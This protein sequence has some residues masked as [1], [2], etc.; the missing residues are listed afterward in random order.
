MV[1]PGISCRPLILNPAADE[2]AK[3]LAELQ[4]RPEVRIC[5]ELDTQLE[6]LAI[7][8]S[9]KARLDR[10]PQ[11]LADEVLALTA[12]PAYQGRRWV[13]YPWCNR[14]VHLL[15]P[16][17]FAE[18][19]SNR[20]LF[21]LDPQQQRDLR[22]KTV[23][24][25]GLSVGRAS[26]AT[27]ALEGLAGCYRLADFDILELSNLN[28]LRCSVADLG[29]NKAVLAAQELYE[30]DP[31][32]DIEVYTDGITEDNIEDFLGGRGGLDLLVE[33]C[34]ELSMKVLLRERCRELR[35][36][37]IMETSDRGM[38]DVERF[39]L[40][41]TRPLLHGL[42]DDVAAASLKGLSDK[43]KVPF[44]LRVLGAT[45]MSVDLAASL[46]EVGE[47]IT[48]WPQLASAVAVGGGIVG[49]FSRRILL[50]QHRESGRF[51]VDL[52]AL[53]HPDRAVAIRV[54]EPSPSEPALNEPL[55]SLRG[56]VASTEPVTESDVRRLV[57]YGIRAP[58]GGNNQG[59]TF[60]FDG[61]A[62]EC[63]IDPTRVQSFLEFNRTGSTLSLGAAVENIVLA[64]GMMSVETDIDF[65]PNGPDSDVLCR[66]RLRNAADVETDPLSQWIDERRTSRAR[67]SGRR[68]ESD[69]ATA[70]EA[71]VPGHQVR[72]QL[73]STD[74]ELQAVA[75]I[76]GTNDRV[77][78]Q[79]EAVHR[80]LMGDVR[81][82]QRELDTRKDGLD[83]T[84]FD[85]RPFEMAAMRVLTRWPVMEKLRAGNR[86][87]TL[88]TATRRSVEAS[89][90][91]GLLSVPGS[92]AKAYF[93]GG[94]AAQ[95]MWLEV[96]RL[97][98]AMQP[99]TVLPA[100]LARLRRGGGEGLGEWHRA[101]LTDLGD[102]FDRLY[103][104]PSDSA[105]IMLFR[106][107][108]APIEPS[109]SV[110]R[111]I[112]DVFSYDPQ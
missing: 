65:Q 93:E 9:P 55:P 22:T 90:A 23:G 7:C 20:N 31:Y 10:D 42:M 4:A 83:L 69:H 102:R 40:E 51:Y 56:G 77:A 61:S 53:L 25:V 41:P 108:Y 106:L 11:R 60:R 16:D 30:I 71:S 6:G 79:H 3:R 76:M 70:I 78:M 62:L 37:V 45:D 49:D 43:E 112:D 17:E 66:I 33:E 12:A 98:V 92:D 46:V 82:T 59:W 32:L 72:L 103:P 68:L 38:V 99:M 19:R 28:R 87:M 5:D 95:R 64:A 91:I 81:W 110:R 89:A 101:L 34:D 100:L 85:M 58:S 2:D 84:T 97:G 21:K 94:R 86:G 67:G 24:V 48:G 57:Q 1:I 15:G 14:L 96:T 36:P 74:E 35:I 80:E 18:V 105:D 26:A 50:N 63:S 104:R 29:L 107:A 39:D 88:E 75:A 47:S 54:P 52:D 73:L 8:R 111:S 44:A 109:R 27:M 13:Y